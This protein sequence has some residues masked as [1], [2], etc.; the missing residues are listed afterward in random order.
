MVALSQATHR[1]EWIVT[2]PRDLLA[3]VANDGEY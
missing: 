2:D 3:D 1:W